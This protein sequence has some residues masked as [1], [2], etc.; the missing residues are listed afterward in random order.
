MK[1]IPMS[2]EARRKHALRRRKLATAG[3][4]GVMTLA[5]TAAAGWAYVLLYD[6]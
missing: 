2:P 6:L 1:K 4:F 3:K 5:V